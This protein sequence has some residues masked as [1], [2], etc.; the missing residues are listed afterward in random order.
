M[1]LEYFIPKWDGLRR[2]GQSK[3]M[4]LTILVP[5]LGY[6]ILFNEQLIEYFELSK[7]VF[8]NIDDGSKLSNETKS[9]LFYFYFGFS[10]L[11]VASLFYQLFCPSLLKE[12]GSAGDYVNEELDLMTQQRVDDMI[13][14]FH[15]LSN[16]G[17]AIES[18]LRHRKDI[19][20]LAINYPGV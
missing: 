6:L 17:D 9:R 8:P 18:I 10:F 4:N 14:R 11:G 13:M 1:I 12:H 15:K 16:F 3:L 19:K 20:D 7:E 5:L 2:I